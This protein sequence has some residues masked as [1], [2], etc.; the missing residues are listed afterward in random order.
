MRGRLQASGLLL[1]LLAGGA[2]LSE[3]RSFEARRDLSV[4]IIDPAK[5]ALAPTPIRPEWIIEG[6]PRTLAAEIARTDDG[7]TR[8][9]VWQTSAARFHW[10]YEFDEV[11]QVLDGEVFVSD[12]THTERRLGPGDIAFFPVAARTLWRVPD[13][14]RKIATIRR[15]PPSPSADV[16][17]WIRIA[18]HWLRPE[19][20]FAG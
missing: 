6:R 15:G 14:L 2:A 17:R 8:V 9:Y 18:K 13:H 11:V 10:N 3:H 7:T 1:L 20:A 4:G 19:P 5:V 16:L 12:Q